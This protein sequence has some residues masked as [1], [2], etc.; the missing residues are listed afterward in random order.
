MRR[1]N[2]HITRMLIICDRKTETFMWVRELFISCHRR[3]VNS[4]EHGKVRWLLCGKI[5]RTHT[6]LNLMVNNNGAMQTIC[7]NTTSVLMKL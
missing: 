4:L 1:A 2:K 5:Q 7:V 3:L 6:L